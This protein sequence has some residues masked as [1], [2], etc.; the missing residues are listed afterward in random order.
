MNF[1]LLHFLNY[2]NV[3]II[4]P[5]NYYFY[6]KKKFE[7]DFSS[8]ILNTFHLITFFCLAWWPA[9]RWSLIQLVNYYKSIRM[10]LTLG[11]TS[12]NLH[13]ISTLYRYVF[14]NQQHK[15]MCNN[16]TSTWRSHSNTV[17]VAN[18][19]LGL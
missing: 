17:H 4:A 15:F 11:Y 1:S 7:E 14:T 12:N 3:W 18:Q 8:I 2:S 9:H 5:F 6:E 16:Q 10:D 13:K 19:L